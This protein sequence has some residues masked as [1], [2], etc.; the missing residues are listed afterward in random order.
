MFVVTCFEC[1]VVRSNCTY[2]LSVFVRAYKFYVCVCVCVKGFLCRWLFSAVPVLA[3]GA[4]SALN[5]G[6]TV[7]NMVYVQYVS[8]DK[9]A[10]LLESYSTR[11]TV[12]YRTYC[13]V[14]RRQLPGV[15][16]LL[17]VS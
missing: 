14:A 4:P 6:C 15:H 10:T 8:F 9:K 3:Q 1:E 2:S 12:R 11:Y 13:T 16:W 5:S 17:G 7:L